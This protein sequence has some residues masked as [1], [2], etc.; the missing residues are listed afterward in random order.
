MTTSACRAPLAAQ[1]R[2]CTLSQEPAQVFNILGV[3]A[4]FDVDVL[5]PTPI[6][7]AVAK[8]PA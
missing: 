2:H 6:S 5:L 1:K 7:T 4:I 8:E 3:T